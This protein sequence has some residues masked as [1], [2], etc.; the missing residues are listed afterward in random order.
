MGIGRDLGLQLRQW[1]D[2]GL[3][4]GGSTALS[5]RLMDALGAEQ[6]L[7]GPL[8]DL[9]SQQIGRAHV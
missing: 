3:D 8:R 6:T 9:A 4:L 1:I 2:A 7:R 5:N